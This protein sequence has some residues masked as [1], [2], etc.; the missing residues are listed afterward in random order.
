MIIVNA[1]KNKAI[2]IGLQNTIIVFGGWNIL[3]FFYSYNNRGWH[4]LYDN[5][6][7]CFYSLNMLLEFICIF[8]VFFDF[9]MAISE[10][11]FY[12]VCGKRIGI[13]F[14]LTCN[15]FFTGF[16]LFGF[17]STA[18]YTILGLSSILYFMAKSH[19]CM[20]RKT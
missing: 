13:I 12:W 9:A 16:F 7:T 6:L 18:P 20:E 19:I 11:I 10:K 17:F 2:L 4:A 14:V 1:L 5:I 8:I 3:N 15:I